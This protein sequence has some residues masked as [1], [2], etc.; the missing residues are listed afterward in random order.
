MSSKVFILRLND[1]ET[2]VFTALAELT[3][4]LDHNQIADGYTVTLTEETIHG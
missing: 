2:I 4:Y 3:V 1:G